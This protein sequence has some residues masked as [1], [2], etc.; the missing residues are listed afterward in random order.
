MT[1]Y[2]VPPLLTLCCFL[3][4][5]GIALFQGQKT[6]VNLLFT[7]ICL[8]GS[9][10]NI[11][12]L[13]A[14]NTTSAD[15]ALKI[16]RIDHFFVVYLFPVY[17]HFFHEHLNI[18]GRRWLIRSAYLYAFVL[19]W[20]TQ[21][22]LYIASMEAH[23]FGFFARGGPLYAFFGIGALFETV[24]V[25]ILIYNAIQK[26][27]SSIQKNKL[28][29]VFAGF[30]VMGVMNGLNIFPIY[31]YSLYPPGNLSFLPL[32]VFGFGLF[33]FNILDMNLLL[34][35]GL[36][37]SILTAFLTC[38]YA[39]II[40]VASKVMKGFD[41]SET[42]YFPV[43]FFLF[44]TFIF[45]PVKNRIQIFVD[46]LFAKGKYDY[47]KTLKQVSQ[48]IASVL[49]IDDI[50][51]YLLDTVV[52]VMK[53]DT[54]A[55]FLTD[56]EGLDFKNFA[57]RGTHH[58]AI[59]AVSF[60][61]GSPLIQ[62]MGRSGKPAIRKALLEGKSA[63]DAG[64][65][66]AEMDKLHA[67]IALPLVF[68]NRLNGFVVLGDKRSGD[69]FSTTD[70]DLLETLSNQ[71]ALAEENAR[72]YKE[73]D[74]LNKNLEQK[75]DERTRELRTALDEKE[76]TQEQLIRSESLAAIGQLVAGVAHELNNP[77]AS[78]TSLLQSTIEDLA[79]WDGTQPP[80]ADLMDDLR[81]ADKELRRAKTI[82]SSLLGLSRQTQTYSEAVNINTV[83]KDALRILRS[84]YKH[85]DLEIVEDFTPDLP[86]IQGNFANLGQVAINIIKNAI[87]AA[88]GS[89]GSIFLTTRNDE[90]NKEVV[91]ECRNTG[92]EIPESI[93]SDIFKPFFTTKAVGEGTGLGL[94][95]CHEIIQ[96]HGGTITLEDADENTVRFVIRLPVNNETTTVQQ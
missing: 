55:L 47:Q 71:T 54:C 41:L 84:Q 35:K 67:E 38:L 19:M 18:Q 30:G 80:D 83:V 96:R 6:R 22:S 92:S 7:I 1:L 78:V 34:K 29:Y 37:Y 27:E 39:L 5:A 64:K 33:R 75:V 69:S 25:L 12:I 57:T 14:F 26:E 87:Q 21:S 61:Q 76:R 73:I 53:V 4:L 44:I 72:S 15:T 58:R 89:S 94:Y 88:A 56:A 36:I 62:V 45:G 79:Q 68:E 82:V 49:D 13:I 91:I 93:R 20:F 43:F 16:S 65:I 70:V 51:K 52:D 10:L 74:D 23:Y 90:D 86:D 11:D 66:V 40:L 31:G 85:L 60:G 77:L 17:I 8:L 50:A 95:I 28:K 59:H 63:S 42:L 48:T 3:G 32:I 81:F 2:S 9:L 24:Y 46:H